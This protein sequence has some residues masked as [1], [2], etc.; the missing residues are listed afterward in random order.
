VV[1]EIKYMTYQ[2]RILLTKLFQ[3]AIPIL[4][5][6]VHARATRIQ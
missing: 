1:L 4:R 2:Y 5:V 6:R 3:Y